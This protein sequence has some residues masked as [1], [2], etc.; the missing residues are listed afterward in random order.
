M[1]VGKV[2][3][4]IN[5]SSFGII[6]KQRTGFLGLNK[7]YHVTKLNNNDLKAKEINKAFKN[8]T[9]ATITIS[10]G[11]VSIKV[12]EHI[13]EKMKNAK[14]IIVD[15]KGNQLQEISEEQVSTMTEE[16]IDQLAQFF[17]Q[18]FM[19]QM[20][21][22]GYG[23]SAPTTS[24]DT[25]SKVTPNKPRQAKAEP[26]AHKRKSS[27]EKKSQSLKAAK[28]AFHNETVSQQREANKKYR[29]RQEVEEK[30]RKRSEEENNEIKKQNVRLKQTEQN[31][32]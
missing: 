5:Q 6:K 31:A 12:Q 10:N 15:T 25:Q 19:E 11:V 28:E 4:G 23:A 14:V 1:D 22:H 29:E 18:I 24:I 21:S 2:S 8:H 16:E 32:R 17:F 3:S 13:T 26:T 7:K 9:I 27:P 20:N 30:T